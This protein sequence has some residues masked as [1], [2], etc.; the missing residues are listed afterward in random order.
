MHSMPFWRQRRH[1][2]ESSHLTLD[3]AQ[4]LQ[5]CEARGTRLESCLRLG[6][7]G[8]SWKAV[9]PFVA[10]RFELSSLAAHR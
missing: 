3:A 9:D 10:L 8:S 4:E 6:A 1:A 2:L 7:G 5:A